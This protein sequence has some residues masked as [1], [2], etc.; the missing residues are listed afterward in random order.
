MQSASKRLLCCAFLLSVGNFWGCSSDE[1]EHEGTPTQSTC[2]TDSTLTYENFGQKFM[3]DYCTRC[4]SSTLS[5]ADRHDAPDGHDFDTLAG[6]LRVAEH[7]DEHAAAGPA[8]V[9]TLMPPDAPRP[10]EAE[11]RQLGEWLACELGAGGAHD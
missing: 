8:A 1:H 3:S 7:V 9:N 6:I 2:P 4:H 11:R 10:T 5:G